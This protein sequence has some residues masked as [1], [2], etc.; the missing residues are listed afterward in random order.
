MRRINVLTPGF[1]AQP[2]LPTEHPGATADYAMLAMDDEHLEPPI[3]FHFQRCLHSELANRDPLQGWPGNPPREIPQPTVTG[4][5]GTLTEKTAPRA[6]KNLYGRKPP[7]TVEHDIRRSKEARFRA[8]AVAHEAQRRVRFYAQMSPPDLVAWN[9]T[10]SIDMTFVEDRDYDLSEV[11]GPRLDFRFRCVSWGGVAPRAVVA[12]DRSLVLM[13]GGRP[14]NRNWMRDVIEPATKKCEETIAQMNRTPEQIATGTAPPLSGGIGLTFN[15][16]LVRQFSVVRTIPLTDLMQRTTPA[17]GA[18]WTALLMFEIFA[19]LAMKRLAGYG[20]CLLQAF[21]PGFHIALA[22]QMREMR[23]HDRRADYPCRSS[24]YPIAT[25]DFGRVPWTA[26]DTSEDCPWVAFPVNDD[27][28]GTWNVLTA[29]GKFNHHKGGHII[30]W[31]LGLVTEFPQA[32]PFSSPV[33]LFGETRYSLLQRT[34]GGI[35]RWLFNGRRTDLDFA[36][37]ATCAEHDARELARVAAH[38]VC[39]ECFPIDIDLDPHAMTW[40]YIEFNRNQYY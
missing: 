18:V 37:N 28:A 35:S 1:P 7:A 40:D 17:A 2:D 20:N 3:P 6:I 25:F 11:C 14:R 29:L 10:Q 19:T 38:A 23:A 26:A 5:T 9:S 30:L 24:L 12:R 34:A 16:P 31:D 13:F 22:N 27:E 21:C 15:E 32:L 33:V 4:N 8:L 39:F 36:I